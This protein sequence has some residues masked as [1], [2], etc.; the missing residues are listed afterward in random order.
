[1]GSGSKTGLEA[2]LRKAARRAVLMA[3]GAV[4]AMAGAGFL[5]AALWQA[6]A[7]AA[8]PVYAS[9]LI[10]VLFLAI[11]ALLFAVCLRRPRKPPP[12]VTSSDLLTVFLKAVQAGRAARSWSAPLR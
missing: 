5:T 10:G 8:G 2:R 4:T 6:L 11:S 12:S 1:M 7:S 9:L 3:A